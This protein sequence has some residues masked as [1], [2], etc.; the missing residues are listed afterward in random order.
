MDFNVKIVDQSINCSF[1]RWTE[2]E[3][4]PW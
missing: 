2:F 1:C 4:Y 3:S